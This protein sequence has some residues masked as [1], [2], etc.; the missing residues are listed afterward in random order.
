MFKYYRDLR[1]R[2]TLFALFAP[3]FFVGVFL[4]SP[5][6]IKAATDHLM[7]NEI[8]PA[9]MSGEKEWVE[10]FNPTDLDIF[11]TDYSLK[12]GSVAAKNLSGTIISGGY[13]VYEV[14][15]GWLNNSGETISLIHKPSTVTIDQV[16][17]GGWNDNQDNQPPAPPSEKSLQRIPNG[18]DTDDDQNDFRI[19][20]SSKGV[21]NTLPVFSDKIFIN[22]IVPQPA[23]GSVNEFVELYNSGV[24]EVDLSSWQIDDIENAGSSP[25]TIPDGTII[26]AGGY[27]TFYNSTTNIVLNDSGDSARLIDPNGDEKSKVDYSASK[28]GQS[29]SKFDSSWQWTLTITP[30]AQNIL[31]LEQPAPADISTDELPEIPIA[32]ARTSEVGEI[33]KIRG[34]VTVIPGILS[35]QYFYIQDSSGGI[36][37]Y[38][39][40]KLFPILKIGDEII[41]IGELA[42]YNGEARLKI[43]EISDITIVSN[44][45]PPEPEKITINEI[46]ENQEGKYISV[47]G[48]V[49]K[50]SGNTFYIHGSGEIEIIIRESSGIK[51]PKMKVGDKVLIAGVVSQYKDYYRI[52]PTVQNDVKIISSSGLPN[53]GNDFSLLI[54]LSI[55]LTWITN[56]VLFRKRKN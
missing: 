7:I 10:L 37:I 4:F 42:D 45:S 44:K 31:T 9:P 53:S 24:A 8:Y 46:G 20:S 17:Y 51:K 26:S 47:I 50:T 49:T 30:N 39:Y 18:Q 48:I 32:S 6:K 55:I 22:E 14:S 54:I 41:V 21:E 1:F 38:S 12:D 16:T 27:L 25:F 11:L 34:I 19:L 3:L 5:Q 52:L 36:Q 28:R 15:S 43:S 2:Y 13:F 56:Q 33:V 35:S 23:D 29:Y 40:G